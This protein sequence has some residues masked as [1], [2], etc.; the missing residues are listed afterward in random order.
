MKTTYTSA[1]LLAHVNDLI[2]DRWLTRR[3]RPPFIEPGRYQVVALGG[4][5]YIATQ[6]VKSFRTWDDC[7]WWADTVR[8][9]M[10]LRAAQLGLHRFAFGSISALHV[11]W[12]HPPESNPDQ[13]HRLNW[14]LSTDGS[15]WFFDMS[16]HPTRHLYRLTD[17]DTGFFGLY[18]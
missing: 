6:L 13:G 16:F 5:E 18:A 9:G 8:S 3:Q 10:V 4:L 14:G 2:G 1:E 12:H 7:G 15:L 11:G 17:E